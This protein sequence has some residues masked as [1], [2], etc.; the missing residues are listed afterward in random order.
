MVLAHRW[1]GLTMAAFLVVVG[2]TGGL[3]AF[4]PELNRLLAPEL[5]PGPHGGSKLEMPA[6]AR[7]AEQLAPDGRIVSIELKDDG[8]ATIT[9]E[10]RAE[11]SPL[12]FDTLYLDDVSGAELGRIRLSGMPTKVSEIMPFVYSV[13]TQLAA[14]DLGGWILGIVALI[15]TLDCFVAVYLTLPARSPRSSKSFFTRWKSAW[16]VKLRSG[17]AYRVNFDIHRAAGLWLWTALLIFAWSGVYMDL[18]GF[19]TQVTE[20]VFDYEQPFWARPLAPRLD[21]GREPLDWEEAY[22]VALRLTEQQ[23]KARAFGVEH[24]I[25]FYLMR[26]KGVYEYVVRSSRDVGDKGGRTMIDFDAYTGALESVSLPTGQRSGTTFTTWLV[27]L[28]M[29]NVFGVIYRTFVCALG[30]IIIVLSATGVFIWWGKRRARRARA[31]HGRGKGPAS[32]GPGAM[33]TRSDLACR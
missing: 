13:H 30:V 2:L 16:L 21:D 5:F 28:H 20:L 24:P 10:A 11:V 23:S 7:R 19:Y 29:A 1:A 3:L 17:S 25:A 8:S 18:N 26:D 6:L 12:D 9:M 32:T 27:E 4:R 15:W 31:H 22:N 33:N 14:G